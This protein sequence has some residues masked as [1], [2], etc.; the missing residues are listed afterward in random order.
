MSE[1]LMG[2]L[3]VLVGFFLGIFW[4]RIKDVM[5]QRKMLIVSLD[6]I[7]KEI[8]RN[9]SQIDAWFSAAKKEENPF[10]V[11]EI[12]QTNAWQMAQMS[13]V[14][15]GYDN[16][17]LLRDISETYHKL[18]SI[19]ELARI[20]TEYFYSTATAMSNFKTNFHGLADHIKRLKLQVLAEMKEIIPKVVLAQNNQTVINALLGLV[21]F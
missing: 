1:F 10:G 20:N 7:K 13:G 2:L 12:F 6:L 4:D 8:E 21:R 9:S 5:S 17:T 19:M 3:L 11:S 16:L 14:F 15:Q 18:G